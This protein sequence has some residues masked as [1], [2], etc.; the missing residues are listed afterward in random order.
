M[1]IQFSA[2]MQTSLTPST[3]SY[4][5]QHHGIHLRYAGADPS[6]LLYPSWKHENSVVHARNPLHIVEAMA[7][8]AD[9]DGT[10]Q[11][12]PFREYAEDGS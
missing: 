11:T 9:F 7:A 4:A 2:H 5:A 10:W 12:T 3:R 1:L 8:S 6:H